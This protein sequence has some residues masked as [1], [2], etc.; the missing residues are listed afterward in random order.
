MEEN[1]TIL[2]THPLD[3]LKTRFTVE[4]YSKS[5][6]HTTSQ[7]FHLEGT[8]GLYKGFSIACLGVIPYEGMYCMP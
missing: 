3:V 1:M 7:I 8:R 2:V 5:I 6:L 4:G